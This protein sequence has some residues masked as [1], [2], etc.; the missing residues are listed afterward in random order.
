MT[1][2]LVASPLGIFH[3]LAKRP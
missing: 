3:L 1:L 2:K